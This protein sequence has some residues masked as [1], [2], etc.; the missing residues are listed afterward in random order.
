MAAETDQNIGRQQ[1]G[2]DV[3]FVA[4]SLST[5]LSVAAIQD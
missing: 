5:Q 4:Q 1:A 3:Y 2:K